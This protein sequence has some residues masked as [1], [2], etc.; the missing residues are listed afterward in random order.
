MTKYR[1]AKSAVVA[2]LALGMAATPTLTAAALPTM[3][4]AP[5]VAAVSAAVPSI[6]PFP[7]TCGGDAYAPPGIGINFG[8]WSNSTCLSGGFPGRM[9]TYH[10]YVPW[11]SSGS[12]CVQVKSLVGNVSATAHRTVGGGCGKSGTVTVPWGNFMG[13]PSLRATSLSLTGVP[14]KF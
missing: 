10:W 9:Q 7:D 2:L 3:A 6:W 5:A 8:P 1:K 13:Y 12:V 14:V 4:Q 11:Y